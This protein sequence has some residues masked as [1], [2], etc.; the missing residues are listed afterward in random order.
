M[1]W[2]SVSWEMPYF[3]AHLARLKGGLGKIYDE[4]EF[5]RWY[6]FDPREMYRWYGFDPREMYRWYSLTSLRD[7]KLVWFSPSRDV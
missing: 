7:V 2:F 5:I 1:L 6:G 3:L 4:P